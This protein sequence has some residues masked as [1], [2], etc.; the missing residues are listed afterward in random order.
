MGTNSIPGG[1][2]TRRR[3]LSASAKIFLEHGYE[4]ASGKMVAE[5]LGVS[6]DSPFSHYGNKE[7]VLLELVRQMFVG[8]F[9]AAGQIIGGSEDRLLL[10]G[11]ETALQLHIIERSE[12][13]RELYVTAY[14]LPSTSG[15]I[16]Q[17]MAPKLSAI[18]GPYQPRSMTLENFYVL[19][20][21]TAGMTRSF[22]AERCTERFPMEQKIRQY[23]ACCFK[24]F[25]VPPSEYEPVI[26]R[27]IQMDLSSAAERVIDRTVRQADA[28]FEIAMSGGTLKNNGL[29]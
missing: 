15:F 1:R 19:D 26:E 27:I 13:L 11:V 22:M 4:K 18:F 25:D 14:T 20:L 29:C 16:H 6:G 7:G 8:Q 24:I 23:L 3:V 5:L 9:N 10:Y 2:L 28:A 12:P 17:S 21:A